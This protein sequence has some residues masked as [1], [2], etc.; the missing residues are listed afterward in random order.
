RVFPD[1]AIR[2]LADA[3]ELAVADDRGEVKRM[4]QSAFTIAR[5]ALALSAS[6]CGGESNGAGAGYVR[7]HEPSQGWT[8]EVPAAW[9]SVVVGPAFARGDPLTD[10]TRLLLRTY[11]NTTPAEALGELAGGDGISVT[12]AGARGPGRFCG[13]SASGPAT[14]ARNTSRSRW[15]SRKTGRAPIWRR[16]PRVAQISRT[17]RR[18]R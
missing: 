12:R 8:A 9:R 18:R 3:C 6:A 1:T 15:R 17:L 5:V 10:P 7:Y 13:G 14:R 11:R 4:H 16:S 2:G